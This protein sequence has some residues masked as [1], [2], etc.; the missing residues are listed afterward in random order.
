MYKRQDLAAGTIFDFQNKSCGSGCGRLA[1]PPAIPAGYFSLSAANENGTVTTYT[2]RPDG[3]RHT[4][5][6][7]RQVWVDSKLAAEI[8]GGEIAN[9]YLWGF[10]LFAREEPNSNSICYECNAHGDVIQLTDWYG[11]KIREY[12]YDAFG[13]EQSPDPAAVSYTHLD[14]YKRQVQ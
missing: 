12:H 13:V 1:N 2:Y 7:V 8:I 11:A 6:G 4:K 9:Q 10:N 5:N 3:L 14:V